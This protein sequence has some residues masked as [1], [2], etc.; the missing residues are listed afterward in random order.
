[1]A[2]SMPILN[3][4]TPAVPWC[5]SLCVKNCQYIITPLPCRGDAPG[6]SIK[7]SISDTEPASIRLTI[8]CPATL[9]VG[10]QFLLR[11]EGGSLATQSK[12]RCISN[13]MSSCDSRRKARFCSSFTSSS[14][15]CRDGERVCD[16]AVLKLRR[17][18]IEEQH[19]SQRGC[20]WWHMRENPKLQRVYF[21]PNYAWL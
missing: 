5:T 15:C 7:P 20:L 10:W 9:C 18:G 2:R 17:R 12:C 1:M 19:R 21:L 16:S 3:I 14:C 8:M 11:G 4:R 6:Y 13:A